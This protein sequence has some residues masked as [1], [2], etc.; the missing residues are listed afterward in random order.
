M[1]VA[2][3]T[4]HSSRRGQR[5]QKRLQQRKRG[6]HSGLEDKARLQGSWQADSQ[7][8]TR[9]LRPL[10]SHALPLCKK[11]RPCPLQGILAQQSQQSTHRS[12]LSSR[13]ATA[14]APSTDST[15]DVERCRPMPGPTMGPAGP[16]P[17]RGAPT[18]K[19]PS[20]GANNPWLG[21]AAAAPP[22]APGPAPA[23]VA[24]AKPPAWGAPLKPEGPAMSMPVMELSGVAPSMAVHWD[25]QPLGGPWGAWLLWML[26]VEI[27]CSC[28]W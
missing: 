5:S 25:G 28:G 12:R 16:G 18:L 6:E 27:R 7:P 1:M 11:T 9:G 2:I 20:A 8:K 14:S 13:A 21:V 3:S 4:S 10:P 19:R 26:E 24:A 23:A 15:M 22:A 17:S